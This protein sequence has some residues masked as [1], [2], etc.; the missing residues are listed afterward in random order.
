MFILVTPVNHHLSWLK[1][2]NNVYA[3]LE[4][5]LIK[6]LVNHA[7]IIDVLSVQLI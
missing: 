4:K 2:E 6:I 3:L 7:Q 5:D 1:M